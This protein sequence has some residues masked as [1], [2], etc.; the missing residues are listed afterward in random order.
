MSRRSAVVAALGRMQRDADRARAARARTA[1]QRQRDVQRAH[2]ASLRARAAHDRET[3]KLYAQARAKEAA[4]A[5]ADLD[6]VVAELENVL[7]ATL[8]VDDF[9]DLE[10]LK[11]PASLPRFDPASVGPTPTPPTLD[12]PAEASGSARWFGGAAKQRE[13]TAQAHLTF[14][15]A[16]TQY[17]SAK[18]RYDAALAAAQQ[19]HEAEVSRLTAEHRR[20]VA[21]VEDLQRGL[22][23]RLPE[24]VVGYL[25]LVLGN[26][27]YP[28]GFPHSWLLAYTPETR[29]LVVE[30]TLP[31]V[32][33]V[34]TAKAFKHDRASDTLKPSP[35]PQTQIRALYASV[36]ARTAIRVV[37]EI[38]ESDRA[39]FVQSLV[40]NGFVNAVHPGT[41][42]QVR[43]CLVALSVS[44]ARFEELDLRTVDPAACLRH[45]E[46][47]V[48]RNPAALDAV[49]Q[50]GGFDSLD[51]RYVSATDEHDAPETASPEQP[52]AGDP[53]PTDRL[54]RDAPPGV[55]LVAGQNSSLT[56]PVLE[57]AVLDA[58]DRDLSV[59]LLGADGRVRDD[60]DFVFFNQ[61]TA[62]DGSVVL[63]GPSNPSSA[64]I[65]LSGVAGDCARLVLLVSSSD[66]ARPCPS[67][68]VTLADPLGD[69]DEY[70]FVADAGGPVTALLLAEVYRRESVWRVRA[71]GQGYADGLAGLAR[72]FG[73]DVQ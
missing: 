64:S 21:G 50:R 8:D 31:T 52:S 68:T 70:H 56:G 73:V 39:G 47:T 62:P 55:C 18:Q 41:G 7:G 53:G 63:H 54:P 57:V 22:R 5:T 13:E 26:A 71:V 69:P 59:V 17:R 6:A 44:R 61:P 1:A 65:D 72:D 15:A 10:A 67:T 49:E 45:L 37:H 43:T 36:I 28:D 34:P 60:R 12:L 66:S 11:A 42:R 16:T 35:R 23:D 24:A 20:R 38:V 46:A 25:D 3:A 32:E 58:G 14:E 33:I 48:S 9:L 29:Q 51:Q 30:Y 40:L 27:S 2:A 4:E 19:A